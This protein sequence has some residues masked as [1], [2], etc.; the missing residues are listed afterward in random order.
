[1]KRHLRIMLKYFQVNLASAM[2]YRASFLMQAFGMAVSNATFVFFWWVA[3]SQV[4]GR[5]GGYDF[6]DVMFIWALSS[7]AFGVA[8]ILFANANQLTRLIVTGELDTFLLQPCNLLLN[9]SCARTSLSAYGDLIYG[10]VLLALTQG[11]D[12]QAWLFFILGVPVGA[13]LMTAISLTAHT[14]T[15]YFGDAS[16]AGSMSLEFIINFCIYPEGIYQHGVRALM[17]SLIPAAFIVHV[18]LRLARGFTI[19]WMLLWLLAAFAYCAFSIWFFYRG[20][21]R[22]ESGNMIVTRL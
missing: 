1:M 12:G 4:G 18:P 11:G 10:I 15:F 21:R 13:L 22:Y 2:E 7:T 17:Y 3:F 19:G 16:L 5:I 14:L 9:V 6:K 8:H 20:L